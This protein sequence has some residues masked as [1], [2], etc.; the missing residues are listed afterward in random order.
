METNAIKT[1]TSIRKAERNAKI[2][3]RY[4]ELMSIEGSMK[5]AVAAKVMDEFGIGSLTTFYE[6]LK[7]E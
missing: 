6:I 2:R 4:A 7:Q 5:M 1:K 3:K